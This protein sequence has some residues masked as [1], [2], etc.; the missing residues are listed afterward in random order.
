MKRLQDGVGRH[1]VGFFGRDRLVQVRVECSARVDR[2]QAVAL[3]ELRDLLG[4]DRHALSE[5]ALE[6]GRPSVIERALEVVEDRQEVVDESRERDLE[7]LLPLLLAALLVVLELRE[8]AQIPVLQVGEILLDRMDLFLGR[9]ERVGLFLL[10]GR[11][12]RLARVPHLDEVV[13]P[14]PAAVVAV[15]HDSSSR[16]ADASASRRSSRSDTARASSSTTGITRVYS[17]RAGP[18]TPSIPVSVSPVP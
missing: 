14:A 5:V 3:P 7:V 18:M 15:A 12:Q 2:D 4:D 1:R 11:L 9:G 6:V 17:R 10:E 13:V 8:L 16:C